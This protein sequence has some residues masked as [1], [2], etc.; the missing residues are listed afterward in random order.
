M[1]LVGFFLAP[2]N[3]LYTIFSE[4]GW[5]STQQANDRSS[6][7]DQQARGGPIVVSDVHIEA[8]R[9][10]TQKHLVRDG[11]LASRCHQLCKAKPISGGAGSLQA[12]VA[13]VVTRQQAAR[14]IA[15]AKPNKANS[16]GRAGRNLRSQ[17]SDWEWE[18]RGNARARCTHSR[19]TNPIS[20]V[21]S[22]KMR[23]RRRNKPNHTQFP[24]P[25]MGATLS[26]EESVAGRMPPKKN[27]KQTQYHSEM[28]G[29]P[30]KRGRRLIGEPTWCIFGAKAV[31]WQNGTMD[32]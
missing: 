17:T 7:I 20:F 10:N 6:V 2:N 29:G 14:P 32:V 19:Q 4:H 5:I 9:R 26:G 1:V 16:G 25:R 31:L 12:V 28:L 8:N 23:L 21:F 18:I 30:A 3:F 15:E 22:L 27:V 13:A 11:C 24:R